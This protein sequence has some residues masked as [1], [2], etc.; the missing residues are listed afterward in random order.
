[1]DPQVAVYKATSKARPADPIANFQLLL[2]K[3][4][5]SQIYIKVDSVSFQMMHD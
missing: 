4:K 1:M 5:C 3:E 2:V